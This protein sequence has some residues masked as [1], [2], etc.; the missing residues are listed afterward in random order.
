MFIKRILGV[1]LAM[2]VL[3]I[4]MSVSATASADSGKIV[5]GEEVM[6]PKF[7]YTNSTTTTMTI[8]S[9]G[10]ATVV[11]SI[12]GYQGLTTSVDIFLYLQQYK[13]GSWVTVG[14]WYKTFNSYQGTL[15][16]TMNVTKGYDYRL[17]ASYYANK[18]SA[19]EN[20]VS[21]SK[22]VRY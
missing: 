8:S 9:S 6:T 3:V 13:N 16:G 18:G 19:W 4:P 14:S 22:T 5:F 17:K 12:T 21:Y 10:K 11:G 1:V 20:I 2:I 7:A 15:S